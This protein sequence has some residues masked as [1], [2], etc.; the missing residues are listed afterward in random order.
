MKDFKNDLMKKTFYLTS[1]FS[2]IKTNNSW[3]INE[4]KITMIFF[5][6]LSQYRVF[7]KDFNE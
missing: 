4:S 3:S 7:L 2:D 5:Q 1:I 6:K